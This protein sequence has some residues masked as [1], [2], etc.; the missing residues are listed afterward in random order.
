MKDSF[1]MVSQYEAA[2]PAPRI[3]ILLLAVVSVKQTILECPALPC[4]R[5]WQEESVKLFASVESEQG[6]DGEALKI[7]HCPDGIIHLASGGPSLSID[8]RVKN[9]TLKERHRISFSKF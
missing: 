9:G 7:H 8:A 6:H 1:M 2:L 4:A 3:G 5:I